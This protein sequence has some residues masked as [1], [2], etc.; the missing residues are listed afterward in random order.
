MSHPHDDTDP[1]EHDPTGM[2]ALLGS[3]PDPGPM[4]ADL[5]ARIEAALADEV[6]ASSS[7]V[8]ALSGPR[9]STGAEDPADDVP[10]TVVPLPVRRSRWHLVAV[11]AAVVGVVGLGGLVVETV[12][13]GGLT[14]SLGVSDD[15][16][17]ASAAG[18]ADTGADPGGE[19]TLLAEDGSL[20][21]VVLGGDRRYTVAGL[22][23]EVRATLPW[24]GTGRRPTGFSETAPDQA[25]Q[26]EDVAGALSTAAGARAC[27]DGL[28]V[29]TDDTVVLDLAMVDDSPA[30]VLV[31][32]SAS[33]E[34]RVWAVSRTCTAQA[35][36]ILAG[37]ERVA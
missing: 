14:A 10:A 15:S 5:V 9:P 37:P 30:A 13:P 28:G 12:R 22:V 25:P 2:R 20:G 8:A 24:D 26:R 17:A 19:R 35:P 36:G 16:G 7:P 1:I 33:G 29:P 3:L 11:A 18:G 32:T 27:A 21:V 6:R 4:P 23:D 34:R 31:A